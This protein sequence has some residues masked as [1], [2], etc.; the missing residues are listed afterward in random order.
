MVKVSILLP[1]YN[2]KEDIISAIQ[3]VINQTYTDWELIIVDDCSIDG[4]YELVKDFV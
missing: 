3:S 4:T 2:N 1:V